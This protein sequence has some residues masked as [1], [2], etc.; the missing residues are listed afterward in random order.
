ML[1]CYLREALSTAIDPF[2]LF[3]DETGDVFLEIEPVLRPNLLK[4]NPY[5]QAVSI[6]P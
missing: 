3:L 5:F 2:A 4:L 1:F 6:R